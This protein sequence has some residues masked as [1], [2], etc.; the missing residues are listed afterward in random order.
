VRTAKTGM[1]GN[2]RHA[3]QARKIHLRTQQ[4]YI[5]YETAIHHDKQQQRYTTISNND[6]PRYETTIR[7]N[8]TSRY[9]TKRDT[10]RTTTHGHA[11]RQNKKSISAAAIV[12]CLG[13]V[14]KGTSETYN[15]TPIAIF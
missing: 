10:S 13:R 12:T 5:R 14:I 11:I 15:N 3:G 2:T 7:N 4:R 1:V 6:T 8:D 9:E